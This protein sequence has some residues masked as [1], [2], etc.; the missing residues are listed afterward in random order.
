MKPWYQEE[1]DRVRAFL[2]KVQQPPGVM[3]RIDPVLVGKQL[4]E[5]IEEAKTWTKL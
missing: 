5:F 4:T 3:V 1:Q 2:K